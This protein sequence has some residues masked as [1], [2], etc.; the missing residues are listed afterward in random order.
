[1]LYD[2]ALLINAYLDA[3]AASGDYRHE[4]VASTGIALY[5]LNYMTDPGGGFHSAE[6]ADSDGEEGKFYV[7]TPAEIKDC[8]DGELGERFCYVYDVTEE[9]NFEHGKS[10]LNLP[11]SIEQCA[12]LKGWDLKELKLDLTAARAVLLM[13]RDGERVRPGKDDKVLVSWNALMIDA[14]ARVSLG[15]PPDTEPNARLTAAEQAA[16]FILQS[17]SRPDGRLLHTWRHGKAKF[18]A[19]LDD[20]AYF[21]N[22]LVTL[23]ETTFD[24][25][26]IDEAVR[27]AELMLKHFEDKERGGFFF[28]ADD[29]EQLI[30][31]NKDLHDA[32]VPSGNAM[33]AT[34]LL[35]LGK[36][37]GKMDYLEAAGRTLA[38]ARNVM[39]RTPTGAGQMLIA[40]DLWLG[41]VN[42]LVLL[43]GKN[44]S[45]NE[46]IVA[47]LH[48]SFLPNAVYAY[49]N[50]ELQQQPDQ[51]RSPALRPLFEGRTATGGQPTLYICENFTCQSPVSG[52]RKVAAEIEKLA[53][54]AT[55]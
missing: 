5:I 15:D 10:I 8:L 40:L 42:E 39:E 52:A 35:R 28:T 1:M 7:W 30:A 9:G 24:E 37:C 13:E 51:A 48:R 43:G 29:H 3:A 33:A 16:R 17:V 55:S 22:A 44:E 47:A 23:Y 32:S 46:S 54:A 26:W 50:L 34:A 27:L 45:D 36:L 11:K 31:R 14:L 41:P 12:A 4:L 49:R 19:Y 53:A 20:Y 18:D 2:N 21:V 6:D 38:V 25:S